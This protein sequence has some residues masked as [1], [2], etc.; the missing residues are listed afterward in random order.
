MPSVFH[1][2][3]KLVAPVFVATLA[4][5]LSSC[6]TATETNS[7]LKATPS[8]PQAQSPIAKDPAMEKKIQNLIAQMSLE[9]KVA[10]MIQADI[11]AVTPEE[12][13]EY[14]LGSVLNGG[15]QYPNNNPDSKISDWVAFADALYKGSMNPIAGKVAIPMFWGVDAVHGHGN[16][17]GATLYPHNVALG[18]S[19]DPELVKAIA[20][21][22]A[23]EVAVSGIDWNFSPT[24]AVARDDRW[25]RS[26]ESYSEDPS[27]VATMAKAY[28]EGLQG[29]ANTYDFLNN[30]HVLA[31]AKHFIGDGGTEF[32]D[33][34]GN[35]MG[36]E[37][38][39]IKLHL[40]GYISAINA[41]V[42]SVMASYSWWQGEHAH[43]NKRLLTDLLKDHLGFDGFVV[44]D[45]QAIGIPTGCT[46]DNCPQAINAG[47]DLFMIPNAPDWKRFL[48]NTVAQVEDGTIAMARIDDA[49]TRILR[50]KMRMKLWQKGSPSERSLAGKEQLIGNKAHRELARRA[51][52]ESM[53]LLKNQGNLLP[54]RPNQRI[55]IA[56][57]GANNL[58]MQ[59][60]GW[61]V[62]WQGAD[63]RN[64]QYPGSTSIYKGL[65][66][67]IEAAGGKAIYSADGETQAKVDAAIVVFGEQP[68][69][70]M[71]GDIENLDTLEL[72]QHSKHSLALLNKLKQKGIPTV[73]V[74]L[75]GRPLWVNKELN[76][77][78]A[79]VAA[80][81][82]GTEGAGVADLL[83]GNAD[84]SAR[85]DFVAKLSVSWPA[86]ACQAHSNI[87]DEDYNPLFPFGF[88]LNYQTP[89]TGWSLLSEDNSQ[90]RYGCRLGSELPKA[91][92]Q[93][94][95]QANGWQYYAEVKTLERYPVDQARSFGAI[96]AE[97]LSGN[98]FG[99]KASWQTG[100]ESRISLRNGR[101]DNNYLA[102]L[103]NKGA[104]LF[105]VKFEQKPKER[106][107]YVL[108]SASTSRGDIDLSPAIKDLAL[109]QWATISVDM[110]CLAKNNGDLSKIVVPFSLQS[111][112]QM[113]LS[114][115][116]VRLE[117]NRGETADI[118]CH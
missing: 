2:A 104:L 9:Q 110:A 24:V 97:P 3:R 32:G 40:P 108:M 17:I 86:S 83:I 19:R 71:Y 29:E 48:R 52:R 7:A 1:L 16:V 18:A 72:Q 111:R 74:L 47:V 4:C 67:A 41:G 105:D 11:G 22:T 35:T 114:L 34:R 51:V 103:A 57:E 84:G 89:N 95:D 101:I 94:F 99:V 90:W 116:N 107:N 30:E 100:E 28:V 55:L 53:V 113:S 58:P 96:K 85:Y 81:Q 33:D 62:T 31:C 59:A 109:N 20:A 68:Y 64:E 61:S 50:V 37:A 75:S 70:E 73:G 5:G 56:G 10:Q 112:G 15:G 76:A 87:G 88:G 12:M 6:Q 38:E 82:P 117:P 23:K 79:F 54:L 25:G 49:V 80:W 13:S 92:T 21:A 98:E 43:T 78:D 44:S 60:G 39:L 63:S 91:T 115:K 69:A 106:L 45:W 77:T 66:D 102:L 8:W 65:K 42:Q 26:Y 93:R 36:D 27:L 14:V 118:Q 46:M